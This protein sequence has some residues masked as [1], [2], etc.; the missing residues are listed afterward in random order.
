MAKQQ[1]LNTFVNN[2]DMDETIAS[3]EQIINTDKKGYVVA[4]NVDVL[5]KIEND[6]YLK[7]IADEADLTLV[8]GKPLVWISKLHHNPVK[9]KISG[10][11]LVPR[12]C[13]VA[14]DK[15]Y[16]VFI[17]GGKDGIAEK[18][19][20]NL[21]KKLPNINIVGTYSPPLGF[22][23][24]N[25]EQEKINTLISNTKPNILIVCFGCPKQEKWIYE[26]YKKYDA[27]VSICAGA[28]VDFLA[29]NIKRAPVWMSEFGLEWFYRFLMEPKRLFKRYFLDDLRI[30]FLIFKY[31]KLKNN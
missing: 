19:K 18:A 17:L 31:W 20:N 9:A 2:V 16:S 23:K 6:P 10:S 29:G 30:F 21:L 5:V 22:E 24:N 1:L 14:S 3:I 28:T 25:D 7:R 11:D 8:D 15:G 26:N 4:V 13:D 27:N 12:L